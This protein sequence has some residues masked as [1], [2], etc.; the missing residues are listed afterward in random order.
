MSD[1]QLRCSK[2]NQVE[3]HEGQFGQCYIKSCQASIKAL[4]IRD[5]N[6]DV[7]DK[8]VKYG[9]IWMNRKVNLTP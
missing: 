2:A 7:N 9:T 8:H 5:Y 6:V 4:P 3:E 1:C